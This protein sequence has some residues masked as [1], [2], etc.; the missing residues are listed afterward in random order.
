[1]N[2]SV[3]CRRHE[4]NIGYERPIDTLPRLNEDNS[5]GLGLIVVDMDEI[6][7]PMVLRQ[8]TGFKII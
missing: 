6:D 4:S 2:H 5:T 8:R 3:P 1:M 7:S